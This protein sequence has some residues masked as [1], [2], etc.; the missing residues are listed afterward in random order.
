MRRLHRGPGCNK[1][2]LGNDPRRRKSGCKGVGA[3]SGPTE[4]RY[5]S[6][7]PLSHGG[8]RVLGHINERCI[9]I[10]GSIVITRSTE[11]EQADACF[12]A[13]AVRWPNVSDRSGPVKIQNRH[14]IDRSNDFKPHRR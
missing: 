2:D 7:A 14:T 6:D 4:N 5:A 10:S 8:Q 13:E 3:T 11:L 9:W 1:T 12:R